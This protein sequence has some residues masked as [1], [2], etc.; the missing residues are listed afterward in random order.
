MG[1]WEGPCQVE[2]RWC[3]ERTFAGQKNAD[4]SEGCLLF[5]MTPVSLDGAAD[6]KDADE[7]VR[8]LLHNVI[9]GKHYLYLSKMDQNH[10]ISDFD[11]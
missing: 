9:S 4:E 10:E 1:S 6:H 8:R 3:V 7:S 5:R 11:I 2:G